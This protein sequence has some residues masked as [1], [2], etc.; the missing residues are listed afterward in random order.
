MTRERLEFLKKIANHFRENP[1]STEYLG[2]SR[3]TCFSLLSFHFSPPE[4][5][6]DPTAPDFLAKIEKRLG[7]FEEQLNQGGLLPKT[8]ILTPELEKTTQKWQEE[9]SKEKP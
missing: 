6:F 7:L 5:I 2:V 3:E 9:T 4:E 8:E 1:S